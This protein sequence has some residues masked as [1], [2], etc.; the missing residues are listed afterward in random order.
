MILTRSQQSK[1][2][3]IQHAGFK[4]RQVAAAKQHKCSRQASEN[5]LAKTALIRIL[6]ARENPTHII[7][8]KT[9]RVKVR[10]IYMSSFRQAGKDSQCQDHRC[11][12]GLG[13]NFKANTTKSCH[14]QFR[15][16]AYS[17]EQWSTERWLK[18]ALLQGISAYLLSLMQKTSIR[19]YEVKILNFST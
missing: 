14:K 4:S 3:A 5:L 19:K 12:H 8:N 10:N 6:A 16:R 13:Y 2:T 15:H 9:V 17:C 1:E 18:S 7:R 11:L